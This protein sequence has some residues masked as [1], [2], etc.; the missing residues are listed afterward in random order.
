M[1]ESFHRNIA[2]IAD[3]ISYSDQLIDDSQAI[4]DRAR[5]E[6][7]L[8]ALLVRAGKDECES[9]RRLLDSLVSRSGAEFASPFEEM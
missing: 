9:A 6:S 3:L 7:E 8:V 5:I 2:R 1:S 4:M